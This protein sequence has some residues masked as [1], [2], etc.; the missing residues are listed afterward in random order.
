VQC[1]GCLSAEV[2]AVV[3][4]EAVGAEQAMQPVWA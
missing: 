4:D 3:R 1:A 2:N